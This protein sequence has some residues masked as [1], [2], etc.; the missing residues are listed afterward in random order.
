M[1]ELSARYCHLEGYEP[2]DAP[3]PPPEEPKMTPKKSKKS[4]KAAAAEETAG[5]SGEGTTDEGTKGQDKTGS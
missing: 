5:P 2:L 4:K 1:Y 3:V